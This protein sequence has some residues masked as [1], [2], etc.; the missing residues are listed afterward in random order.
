MTEN[1]S[2]LKLRNTL[3]SVPLDQRVNQKQ[4]LNYEAMKRRRLH[5]KM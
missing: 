1:V 4:F 2:S 5:T 3:I